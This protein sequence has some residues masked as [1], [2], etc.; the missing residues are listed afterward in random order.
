MKRILFFLMILTGCST[1]NNTDKKSLRE[2]LIGE[3]N[4]ISM[5]VDTLSS[6]GRDSGV[7]L[8]VNRGEW[9]KKLQIKPIRTF[10]REDSTWNSAHYKLNDSLFFDPSG[11]W[12]TDGN[13][14]I[15]QQQIPRPDTTIFAVIIKNDTA[16]FEGIVDLDG[17]GTRTDKYFGEQVRKR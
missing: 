13:K 2:E 6:N 10:F 5:K 4:N 7:M 8:L 17:D 12:W 1:G 3:W 15:M 9:E 14:L 16:S 11:K